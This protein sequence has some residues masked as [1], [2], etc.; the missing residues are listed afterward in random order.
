MLVSKLDNLALKTTQLLVFD[1]IGIKI[2]D[3]PSDMN[4]NIT[5]I[6]LLTMMGSMSIWKKSI[7]M[8]LV[9]DLAL[10]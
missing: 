5:I 6:F 3:S 1:K 7:I 2:R 9:Y 10:E 4:K 8:G